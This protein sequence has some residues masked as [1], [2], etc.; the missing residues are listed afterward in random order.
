MVVPEVAVS[1]RWWELWFHGGGSSS[2]L[3]QINAF[4]IPYFIDFRDFRKGVTDGRTDGRTD[5][6]TLL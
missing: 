2:L 6:Q 5:G 3:I 1:E 4:L